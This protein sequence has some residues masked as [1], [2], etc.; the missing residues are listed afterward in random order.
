MLGREMKAVPPK[1]NREGRVNLRRARHPLI[2]PEK[3]VPSNLW[4]GGEFTTL[5]ITGPNTGGKT[6]TLK[7]VGLLSPDDSGGPS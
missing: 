2:D 3:V 5:I 4:L 7:T 1:I 6:V